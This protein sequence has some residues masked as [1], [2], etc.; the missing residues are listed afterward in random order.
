[1][2]R[3]YSVL[4]LF[5]DL[6]FDSFLD[7]GGGEGY[8]AALVQDAF[9][10]PANTTDLSVEA[11]ER[12]CELFAIQGCASDAG[13]L[14]FG[15]RSYDLVLCSEVIEHL[16]QPVRA[17]SE[18]VRVAD[19]HV[20]ITTEQ[21]CPLG[22]LERILRMAQL[23]VTYPHA[24]RNW[25]T[26]ADFRGLLGDEISTVSQRR[27]LGGWAVRY[28]SERS[29]STPQA[30]R[31]LEILTQTRTVDADHDGITILLTRGDLAGG[32]RHRVSSSRTEERRRQVLDRILGGV[33]RDPEAPCGPGVDPFLLQT[34]R[35]VR[36]IGRLEPRATDLECEGC[37][38]VYAVRN[39]VPILI[40]DSPAPGAP[41][42]EMEGPIRILSRGD[43]SREAGIRKMVPR[44]HAKRPTRAHPLIKRSSAF[45]LRVLLFLGRP[46]SVRSKARR[47][48]DHV[49]N[50]P[51]QVFREIDDA[52]LAGPSQRGYRQ[53]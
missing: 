14:P 4:S 51:P 43:R 38:Q 13:Q 33:P 18:L 2:A 42:L 16:S 6:E 9:N 11:C 30:A 48:F 15:E 3:T 21:I 32:D 52:L 7:V 35:C 41:E 49:T 34:L 23:D 17:I 1:M 28:F 31:A 44:F 27:N 8:M 19:K 36:C 10:V 22:E 47:I 26:P 40:L 5:M 37:A 53:V 24:E 50:R 20:V 12:A 29:L 46:G 45:L 25:F 39:G